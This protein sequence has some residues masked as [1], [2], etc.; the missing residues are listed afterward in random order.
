MIAFRDIT[1]QDKDTI[2]AYTMNSCRRN[3]DLFFQLMQLA[4]LVSHQV[5]HYQ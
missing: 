1:I 3:C 2:T 4:V 5:C